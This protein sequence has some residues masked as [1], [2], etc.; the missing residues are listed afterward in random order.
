MTVLSGLR[1]T[2][3]MIGAPLL[4]DIRDFYPSITERTLD[5]ALDLAKE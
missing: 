1:S 3:R 2:R 4:N 5:R